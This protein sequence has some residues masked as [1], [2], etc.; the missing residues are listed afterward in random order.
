MASK[1]ELANLFA[2]GNLGKLLA[3]KFHG[4]RGRLY[5][6]QDFELLVVFSAD[7]GAPTLE[8]VE[9]AVVECYSAHGYLV[10]I[11]GRTENELSGTVSYQE[12]C[13]SDP[14][15]AVHFSIRNDYP[16]PGRSRGLPSL[17]IECDIGD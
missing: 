3:N 10:K 17:W 6:K 8:V 13:P 4:T 15:S 2:N 9:A 7:I 14:V 1:E 12:T 16:Y 11:D 5:P